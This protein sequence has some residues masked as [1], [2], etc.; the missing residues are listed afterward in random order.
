MKKGDK[1]FVRIDSKVEGTQTNSNDF[2][3]H[4]KYLSK[5]ASERYFIGGGFLNTVGGMIVFEA[6]DL[7]EAKEV[8]D[9]DPLIKRSLYRY[10]LFEWDLV[11]L[12]E[13]IE[14][15]RNIPR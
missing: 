11:I 2:N 4:I 9:N 1:L 8:A 14:K 12:S 5:V 15:K 10:E 6:K 3:D 13:E 7:A